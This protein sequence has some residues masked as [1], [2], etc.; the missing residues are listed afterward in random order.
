[1][2]TVIQLV[3]KLPTFYGTR[4]FITVFTKAHTL[5]FFELRTM[6]IR[7]LATSNIPHRR[8]QCERKARDSRWDDKPTPRAQEIQLRCK[9]CNVIST[10]T[11]KGYLIR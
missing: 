5:C 8:E 3:N 4:R 11:D 9:G 10:S 7:I 6:E 1:M 2:Q